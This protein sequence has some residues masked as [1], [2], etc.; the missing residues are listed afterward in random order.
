M[1]RGVKM[2]SCRKEL[3]DK[4]YQS[5]DHDIPDA[6][7]MNIGKLSHGGCINSEACNAARKM[8]RLLSDWFEQAEL[9]II[10]D[11]EEVLEIDGWCHLRNMWLGGKANELSK[12]LNRILAE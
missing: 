4:M 6:N 1:Q 2:V 8:W 3:N 10:T 9:S 11:N 12:F 5:D 7:S